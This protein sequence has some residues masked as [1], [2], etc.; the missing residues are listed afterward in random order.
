MRC[1]TQVRVDA[2][3]YQSD[4]TGDEWLYVMEVF[5]P[6]GVGLMLCDLWYHHYKDHSVGK[7]LNHPQYTQVM[8]QMYFLHCWPETSVTLMYGNNAMQ[9]N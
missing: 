1:P 2:L 9:F 4:D 5:Q 8:V 7:Y 6:D 3:H